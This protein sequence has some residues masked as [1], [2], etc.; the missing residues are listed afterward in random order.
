MQ[1]MNRT[2]KNKIFL[3]AGVFT[4]DHPTAFK[5]HF[6]ATKKSESDYETLLARDS[7]WSQL[8]AKIST[9]VLLKQTK[10]P[11][12]SVTKISTLVQILGVCSAENF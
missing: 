5:S 4:S 2:L 6:C 12:V 11:M 7:K 1:K 8:K 3:I 9:R 10:T